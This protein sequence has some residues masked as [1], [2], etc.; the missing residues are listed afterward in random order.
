MQKQDVLYRL[1]NTPTFEIV[2]YKTTVLEDDEK[3]KLEL[4]YKSQ[5][6]FYE[7]AL[8][9]SYPDYFITSQ[10]KWIRITG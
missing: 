9:K 2:D 1:K 7:K 3:S 6:D 5:L 4:S 8:K 10:L